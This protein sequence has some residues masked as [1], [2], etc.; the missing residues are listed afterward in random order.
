MNTF[1]K[2]NHDLAKIILIQLSLWGCAMLIFLALQN[3][4]LI[5]FVTGFVS[6][7]LIFAWCFPKKT[8]KVTEFCFRYRWCLALLVFLT[9]VIFR[10]HGS[11][12]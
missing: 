3:A 10:V 4:A 9:C 12:I 8:K 7:L 2:R 11:S 6:I 5:L 1:Q